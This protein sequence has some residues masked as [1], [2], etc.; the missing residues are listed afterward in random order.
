MPTVVCHLSSVHKRS[1]VRVFYKECLSLVKRGYKIHLVLAD[2][3]GNNLIDGVAVHDVGFFPN[4]FMRMFFSPLKVLW[5]GKKTRAEVFHF[6]DPE[7]LLVGLFLKLFTKAK[8]VYDAHESYP[9]DVLHKDYLSKPIRIIASRAIG[10]LEGFVAK[11]LDA[12][13]TVTDYHAKRFLQ[14]NPN[15]VVVC[16][17]PLLEEWKSLIEA[18]VEKLPNSLCYV[19]SITKKRGISQLLTAIENLDVTLHLAGAYEPA[20]YRDELK[21]L[22]AWS[23]VKEYGYVSREKAV[24]LISQAQIGVMLFLPEPNH[25]NSL[26]TKVFEY[27]AGATCVVVSDFPVYR[28]LITEQSCGVSVNPLKIED[29]SNAI[30]A[31]LANPDECSQMGNRGRELISKTYNWEAQ[32]STLIKLYERLTN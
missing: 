32:E 28:L 18:K 19:G 8:V 23:K 11:W 10:I 15:T 16:N 14:Y 20:E 1:D 22:A 12:V 29:I 6:H 30:H 25:I 31:L 7:L 13:V 26:S 4:R 3:Q 17:Y 21:T 2:G 27:M 5:A 24:S 9:D